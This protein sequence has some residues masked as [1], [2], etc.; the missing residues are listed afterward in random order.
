MQ[1]LKNLHLKKVKHILPCFKYM[2]IG[3][4]GKKKKRTKIFRETG[5]HFIVR[6]SF[7]NLITSKNQVNSYAEFSIWFLFK[8]HLQNGGHC[9]ND[10][11]E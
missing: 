4:E 1:P 7:Q 5:N 6:K 11:N 10:E 2:D 8:G 3:F 9:D